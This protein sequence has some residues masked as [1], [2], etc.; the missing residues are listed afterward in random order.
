MASTQ[1]TKTASLNYFD[2]GNKYSTSGKTIYVLTGNMDDIEYKKVGKKY[3]SGRIKNDTYTLTD[4][5]NGFEESAYLVDYNQIGGRIAEGEEYAGHYIFGTPNKFIYDAKQKYSNCGIDT[6]LNILSMGGII[7]IFEPSDELIAELKAPVTI[8]YKNKYHD[9]KYMTVI[10]DVE[11]TS[12]EEDFT[13]WAIQNDYAEHSKDLKDYKTVEDIASQDGGSRFDEVGSEYRYYHDSLYSVKEIL[14]KYNVEGY[15]ETYNPLLQPK[16]GRIEHERKNEGIATFIPSAEGKYIEV[17]NKYADSSVKYK[18]NNDGTYEESEEGEYLKLYKNNGEEDGY[19]VINK[20]QYTPDTDGQYIRSDAGDYYNIEKLQ[21]IIKYRKNGDQ[22][23]EDNDNG[24]YVCVSPENKIYVDL[25]EKYSISEYVPDKDGTFLLNGANNAIDMTDKNHHHDIQ[26]SSKHED[27][28]I[29]VE[30]IQVG[31]GEKQKTLYIASDG[32]VSIDD[33]EYGSQDTIIF[34]N[35]SYEKLEENTKIFNPETGKDESCILAKDGRDLIIRYTPTSYVRIK[36]FYPSDNGQQ[37]DSGTANITNIQFSDQNKTINELKQDLKVYDF[38]ALKSSN[39]LKYGKFIEDLATYV[40]QGRAVDISVCAEALAG[41]TPENAKINHAIVI[42][43]VSYNKIEGSDGNEDVMDIAGFFVHDTGGWLSETQESQF[44]DCQTLYNAVTACKYDKS[45]SEE[46]VESYLVDNK[47]CETL[48]TAKGYKSWAD[49]MNLTGNARRNTLVGNSSKNIL[50]GGG[51]TDNLYGAG[52]NDS[53]YGDE[54][55]DWLY[56]GYDDDV[57]YGGSGN[58]RYVF[59]YSDGIQNDTIVSGNGRDVLRFENIKH[60]QFNYVH[61]GDDLI[62]YYDNGIYFDD[63]TYIDNDNRLYKKTVENEN[64]KWTCYTKRVYSGTE[65]F[66]KEYH[67]DDNIFADGTNIYII[68]DHEKGTWYCYGYD[69]TDKNE[70]FTLENN[71]TPEEYIKSNIA[72]ALEEHE[73]ANRNYCSVTIKDYYLKGREDKNNVLYL[74]DI[75][76]IKLRKDDNHD[77]YY[78]FRGIIQTAGVKYEYDKAIS[79]NIKPINGSEEIITGDRNDTINAGNGNDTISSGA[80]DD[81]IK[82]GSGKNVINIKYGNNKIYGEKGQNTVKMTGST[83][84]NTFYNA[85]GRNDIELTDV[86]KDDL[87]FAR[88]GNNL[89]IIYGTHNSSI[90]IQNYFSKKGNTSV[91]G[92]Q[93]SDGYYNLVS[94]YNN[95]SNQSTILTTITGTN[96]NGNEFDNIIKSSGT[97]SGGYGCDKIYGLSGSDTITFNSLYDGADTIYATKAGISTIDLSG[98]VTG[99]DDEQNDVYLKLD[100]DTGF[101]DGYERYKNGDKNYAYTKDKNDLIIHYG[102][103]LEQES[104]SSIRIANFFNKTDKWQIKTKDANEDYNLKDAAIYFEGAEDKKNKLTGSKINDIIYGA[105]L[106]DT[107][108][109]GAGNDTIIGGKGDD[110][111][112]GGAGNNVIEYTYGNGVD[113]INLTKGE[114]LTINLYKGEHEKFILEDEENENHEIIKRNIAFEVDKKGNLVISEI[115]DRGTYDEYKAMLIIKNFGKKDVTGANTTVKLCIE[116]DIENSKDLREGDFLDHVDDFSVNKKSYTGNWHSEFIDATGLSEPFNTKNQGV[117]VNAGA[118]NDTIHGS[119]FN[120]T[121]KGGDGN[122]EIHGGKGINTLDGGNGN[123]IYYLFS[124]PSDP[125][126]GVMGAKD[127]VKDTGKLKDKDNADTAIIFTAC[128]A[129]KKDDFYSFED[130][131]I[132]FNIANGQIKGAISIYDA[133]NENTATLTNV[134]KIQIKKGNV[135]Y[136]YNLGQVEQN[137]AAWFNKDSHSQYKD[138]N[139]ALNNANY[140]DIQTLTGYFDNAWQKLNPQQP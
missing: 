70:K 109:G 86:S 93:L 99:K 132:S 76:S 115:I 59:K 54:G 10:P 24:N 80:G 60:E 61:K 74:D 85:S 71:A 44:I 63:D 83:G 91:K 13:L 124:D 9:V 102:K 4:D 116:G 90:T 35:L 25:N 62:I 103:T 138:L 49:D 39:I 53:L 131:E 78:D 104:M 87:R 42:T 31:E 92:I 36:N 50:R 26:V 57:L 95:I 136:E 58:D 64:I 127:I 69:T 82:A 121:L 28:T 113:T 89:Q 67:K 8:R 40:K 32:D 120:D 33:V 55:D 46:Y 112:T 1:S 108:V 123:D 98:I 114:S 38:S 51:D 84:F 94:E 79:Y 30:T 56:G 105:N 12:T 20:A 129:T 66:N 68:I 7:D 128:E 96:A 134:E 130:I 122:D 140:D 75:D 15:I 110:V 17:G 16:N 6:A 117:T 100:G 34:T 27:F 2:A 135:T 19:I 18:K 43:G 119:E 5:E 125:T 52:G 14:K 101:V 88:N 118:G 29:E 133:K 41:G 77:H 111:L 3:V 48:V 47:A 22:Y 23:I 73:Y 139:T 11:V 137:V 45:P 81:I 106:N 65:E 72:Q 97:I 21:P 126:K 107:L 37:E